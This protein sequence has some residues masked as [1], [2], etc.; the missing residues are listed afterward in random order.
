VI[1]RF[2]HDPDDFDTFPF[3]PGLG[4]DPPLAVS[5]DLLVLTSP[6]TGA[7]RA[8][9]R[10]LARPTAPVPWIRDTGGFI[11]ANPN[12]DPSYYSPTLRT[13]AGALEKNE[14]RFGLADRLGTLGGAEGLQGVLWDLL[15]AVAEGVAPAEAARGACAGMVDAEQRTG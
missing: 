11:A 1:R 12:T 14:I 6:A 13:L 5:S 15:R 10:H 3:P 9:I 7:A 8:L 4:G 2:A